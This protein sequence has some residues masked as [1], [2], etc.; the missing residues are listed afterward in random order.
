VEDPVHLAA[1]RGNGRSHGVG[2]IEVL[3]PDDLADP[4]DAVGDEDAAAAHGDQ[5]AILLGRLHPVDRLGEHDIGAGQ[6]LTEHLPV[7]AVRLHLAQ[8]GPA[9]GDGAVGQRGR[10]PAEGQGLPLEQVTDAARP[11]PGA[12]RAAGDDAAAA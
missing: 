1:D 11:D 10:R 9:G 3:G 4:G 8:R 2:R 7:P 5:R 12:L 6:R